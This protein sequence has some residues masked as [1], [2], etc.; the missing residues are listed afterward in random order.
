MKHRLSV[1]FSAL[2]LTNVVSAATV[3]DM[4]NAVKEM[5]A[6]Q[7]K[8]LRVDTDFNGTTH[9]RMQQ[10]FG[11]YPVWGATVNTHTPKSGTRG[12]KAFSNGK[13][14][15][16]LEQDLAGNSRALLNNAQ[17]QKALHQAQSDF[18]REHHLPIGV[19]FKDEAVKTV[20]YIDDKNQAH[21]AFHVTFYYD[22]GMTGAHR[23]NLLMDVNSL[24]AYQ[25]WDQVYYT[26]MHM[27][28][29]QQ[30]QS[31]LQMVMAGGIGGNEKMGQ[32]IY[33]GMQSHLPAMQMGHAEM[34]MSST[35]VATNVSV[36]VLT[37]HDVEVQDVSYDSQLVMGLCG[38]ANHGDVYWLSTDTDNTRWKEDEMNGAN[39]PSL[40]AFYNATVIKKMYNDWYGIEPL[41]DG[42]GK[43][44][45]L[46]M[47]THY[48]RKFDN[49]FWDGRRMTFGDGDRL[50][51]PLTSLDVTAHEIGHGFT[52]L[53][54]NIDGYKPQ[55]AALHESFSDMA[56]AAA[57]YYAT[58]ESVWALAKDVWKNEG[59]MRYM[60][61]P[62]KDGHSIDNLKDF[63]ATEAHG[64]GG[65]TNKAFYLLATSKG[66]DIHKAFNVW[67]KA[68]M[69]YWNSSMT[70][71][72]EAACGV[73]AATNDYGYNPVAV[74]VSFTKVG[75]DTTSC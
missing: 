14:Y 54:S 10:M 32:R 1:L 57:Q 38:L 70:T 22:D 37:N 61:N 12:L 35:G 58:G 24:H 30:Q 60:D 56:A 42:Q 47:R 49:A 17:Q 20:V 59:A 25:T 73:V 50:F 64:A 29:D 26:K 55:M 23:P 39:S 27:M 75:I 67:M 9:A 3:I 69:H 36:C 65:I 68:N 74:H 18:R 28:R 63:D 33:D 19:K 45:K 44:V 11:N 71:L 43:A 66:W 5:P 72:T 21:Y 4:K 40:D 6:V 48:G 16:G 41:V 15:Q 34:Q 52:E 51:Y 2:L 13:V 8:Q 7:L 53:H 62:T 46:I 31:Q